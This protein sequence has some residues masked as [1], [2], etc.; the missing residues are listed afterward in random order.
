MIIDIDI[1]TDIANK[2]EA[3]NFQ[4]VHFPCNSP[5]RLAALFPWQYLPFP[6]CFCVGESMTHFSVGVDTHISLSVTGSWQN[7][8]IICFCSLL[9]WYGLLTAPSIHSSCFLLVLEPLS[10]SRKHVCPTRD[11]IPQFSSLWDM[12]MCSL[13]RSGVCNSASPPP[14]PFSPLP[15]RLG[16][17]HQ[18]AP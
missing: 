6:K 4:S 15:H 3:D 18:K 10:F 2:L 13:C 11:Q 8:M 1:D 16:W 14:L 9:V 5:R 12:C 17:E 7:S